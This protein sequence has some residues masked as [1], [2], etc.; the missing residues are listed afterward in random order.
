MFETHVCII[1]LQSFLFIDKTKT[2]VLR[3]ILYNLSK[4]TYFPRKQIRN[5]DEFVD[6]QLVKVLVDWVDLLIGFLF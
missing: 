2:T 3:H 6:S 5:H 4:R 1:T